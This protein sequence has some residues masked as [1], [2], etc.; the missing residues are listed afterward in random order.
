MI[1]QA[2]LSQLAPH[3]CLGCGA[4]GALLCSRCVANLDMV[5]ERCYRCRRLSV[6]G[7]TC[8]SCR[9]SSAVYIARA[10]TPYRGLAKDIVWRLKFSGAQ[11]AAREMAHLMSHLLPTGETIVIVPI[12]TATTRVR[13]RGYDQAVLLARAVARQT[14]KR[15]CPA[16]RRLGQHHQVGATRV[17][18]V[19]QLQ[20]AY[21]CIRPTAIES[22]HVILIDDVSTTGATLEAAAT[23][24]KAAG[25]KR[26]S[27]LTFAQA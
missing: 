19:T 15:Y 2:I 25:A 4:E 8:S 26:V 20:E 27:A 21:R 1:L 6:D 11:A 16:L 10:V 12:P 22:A 7:K 18:R 23:I 14:G 3:D 5:P 13:T 9:S 17:Q 24:M